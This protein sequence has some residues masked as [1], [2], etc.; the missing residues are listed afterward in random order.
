MPSSN[1]ILTHLLGEEKLKSILGG[2]KLSRSGGSKSGVGRA[3][4]QR[5]PEVQAVE[6]AVKVQKAQADFERQGREYF[7][8]KFQ[9]QLQRKSELS[10]VESDED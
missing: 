2:N 4:A 10:R 3:N 5:G 8:K 7:K 9:E 1:S 6:P